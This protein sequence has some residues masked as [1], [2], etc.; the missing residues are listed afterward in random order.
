MEPYDDDLSKTALI[1]T[2]KAPEKVEGGEASITRQPHG[3]F[4]RMTLNEWARLQ[5]VYVYH[6]F[7][8]FGAWR[9][10]KCI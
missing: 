6:H 1:L 5:Y 9:W 8:Q 4:G 10:A 2:D 7:K 3:F